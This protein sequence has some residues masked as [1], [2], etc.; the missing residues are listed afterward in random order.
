VEVILQRLIEKFAYLGMVV[1]FL[2]L[3]V[4]GVL[5]CQERIW[6]CLINPEEPRCRQRFTFL[7]EC[8][9]RIYDVL[10]DDDQFSDFEGIP[11]TARERRAN[12]FAANQLMP[13][14]VTEA[15][16]E[17]VSRGVFGVKI[18]IMTMAHTFG[19]SCQA[20]EIRLKELKLLPRYPVYFPGLKKE[21]EAT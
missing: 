16:W 11:E 21:W 13:A 4:S 9:H 1:Q 2:P 19:V 17:T 5:A 6:H 3:S 20:M 8:A 18:H 12:Q 10:S 7:H 14:D 15:F